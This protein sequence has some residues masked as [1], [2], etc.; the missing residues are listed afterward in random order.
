LVAFPPPFAS[1]SGDVDETLS[2]ELAKNPRGVAPVGIGGGAESGAGVAPGKELIQGQATDVA[3]AA[4]F[5]PVS[6]VD[7][8]GVLVDE[9]EGEEDEDVE[10][11]S[12]GEEDNEEPVDEPADELPE[13]AVA[14][15]PTHCH[16]EAPPGATLNAADETGNDTDED[17][18]VALSVVSFEELCAEGA[19]A[20]TGEL[21]DLSPWI[22]GWVNALRALAVATE[23]A[24]AP[25]PGEAAGVTLAP[26]GAM[27]AA[28]AAARVARALATGRALRPASGATAMTVWD[29]G[30]A[31][32]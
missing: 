18:G 9:E 6:P 11:G 3:P 17:K 30:V 8:V 15:L 19:G 26:P 28:P 29:S 16:W 5:D 25:I 21:V 22:A 27:R 20:T 2:V 14:A 24:P 23:T 31:A 4:L 10:D 32:A 13:R 1:K 7:V 12:A